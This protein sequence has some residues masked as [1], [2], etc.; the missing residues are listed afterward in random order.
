MCRSR[1][2]GMTRTVSGSAQ[3]RHRGRRQGPVEEVAT[4]RRKGRNSEQAARAG[5]VGL[6]FYVITHLTGFLPAGYRL[7]T[8][9]ALGL[10]VFTALG[11]WESHHQMTRTPGRH[12]RRAHRR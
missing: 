8:A 1:A 7:P 2:A 5:F 12:E 3:G 6:I 9:V 4:L 10:V 11:L